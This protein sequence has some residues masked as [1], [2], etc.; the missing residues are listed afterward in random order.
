MEG[1]KLLIPLGVAL[2]VTCLATPLVSRLASAL[3]VVDRPNERGVSSRAGMP[4]L[5]GL[6]VALGFVVGLFVALLLWIDDPAAADH[7]K[8]LG[9]GALLVL[10]LGVADDRSGLGALPKFLVQLVAAAIAIS[11]G[12][13]LGHLTDPVSLTSWHLPDPLVW[14]VS[15]LWIVGITNALNLVDGLDGLA[16]GVGAIIGATLTMIAWQAGQ[17][18]G[19]CVGIALV[20]A[21]MGFLPFNFAPARI[22]LGDTGSLFIGYVLALLA[23][24]G[25]RQVSL[26]TFVVPLLAL[27][28]A[29][30]F[31]VGLLVALALWIDDPAAAD[32]LKGLGL[33]ALLVLALG[34]ADDRS[35]LGAWPK[36]LVQL[37]AAAIAI[38]YG[39]RLGHLTD[40]VS[41]TS[42]HLPDPL[43]WGVSALWIVGITNALNLVDGLDGLATGVGAI[44]GA[45]LTMIAWQAGQPIGICVGIALVGALMGFLPFNFAPARIFL[46]DTGSLFI[47]YVLALLALEGYRQVSLLT[48]VVP[49]LALA[50][51]ILDTGLSIVR[52]VVRRAPIFSAD[53]L[54]M[55]HRLLAS[56][57]SPRR[58]VLQFYF[59]TACFCLIAVSFTRLQGWAALLFLAA[60]AAL[61]LRLLWNLDVLSPDE[62]EFPVEKER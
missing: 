5:G 4:L 27:A 11:Y 46:G 1:L 24:E 16:T 55:H 58:A 9:L 2:G 52:R 53:R 49:L 57:G 40:P 60:V 59:L 23:L 38:S 13:R 25:Y 3:R 42:W 54:H 45:T 31:V 18:I 12:F 50:V 61:T 19:I 30:G 34:V 28:V 20:G 15:A 48:F 33:G 47:G 44:I 17:P 29:L 8:G 39:F 43:V 22:F 21:L 51:P 62:G 35:S 32:H 37:A 26:L 6:A 41:L 10:A 56:E 36:F 7:L 14:G